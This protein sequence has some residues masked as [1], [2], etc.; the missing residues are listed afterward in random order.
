MDVRHPAVLAAVLALTGVAPASAATTR[1]STGTAPT[2][3]AVVSAGG[4]HAGFLIPG[5][6]VFARPAAGGA[7]V[8]LGTEPPSASPFNFPMFASH[9]GRYFT[10]ATGDFSGFRGYRGDRAT[11][12]AARVDLLGDGSPAASIAGAVPLSADGGHVVFN[13]ASPPF[14]PP[15]PNAGLWAR[16]L[17][18]GTSVRAGFLPDGTEAPTANA[19]GISGDGRY[20]AFTA[21]DASNT[22]QVYVRDRQAATTQ[23]LALTQL[24]RTVTDLSPD[25]R[26]IVYGGQFD[27]IRLHDRQTG[28]DVRIAGAGDAGRGPADGGQ[29]SA[30]GRYV[31]YTQY[32]SSP[33]GFGPPPPRDVF[34]VDRLAA[35]TTLVSTA[36]DGSE[37]GAGTAGYPSVSDDGRY[38]AFVSDSAEL[39]AGDDN[40]VSDAFLVDRGAPPASG[41]EQTVP[42]GG[43]ATLDTVAVTVP[44]GGAV[45]ITASAAGAPAG[46]EILGSAFTIEAPTATGTPLELAFHV[47]AADQ[48]ALDAI[49][50]FRNGTIVPDCPAG[51]IGADPEAVCVASR[52]LEPGGGRIEVLAW[53]ASEWLLAVPADAPVY[54]WGGFRSPV[55]PLPAVNRAEAGRSVPVKFSL[56]GDQGLDVLAAGSPA[57]VPCGAP[58]PETGPTAAVAY[59]PVT[60]LYQ[61]DWKTLKAWRGTCRDLVLRLADGSEQRARFRF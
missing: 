29:V 34:L 15:D 49:E 17:G 35:S 57:S 40:G 41:E 56:G 16:D 53:H 11:G 30:D 24:N 4:S 2:T 33:G 3:V 59:D 22:Q 45:T 60:Q 6:G 20:I 55:Q 28:V 46:Y 54:A 18:A 19:T 32:R 13:V 37:V 48:A 61:Y 43:T 51:G 36:P 23:Q 27:P 5:V 38:V 8:Q 21:P 44:D 1:L 50:V 39:V 9:D 14:Q 7:A 26:Y 12:T 10:W 47:E 25:G 52:A 31:V 42:A 58:A